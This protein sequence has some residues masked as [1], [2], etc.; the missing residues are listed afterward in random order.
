MRGTPGPALVQQVE[1]AVFGPEVVAP[2]RHAVRLVDGEQRAARA[3][4]QVEEARRQQALGR[5]V[6]Q[7]EL[8][9]SSA[10]DR[11][12]LARVSVELRNAA[13]T[14]SCAAPRPGPA[15]AR[16]AARRRSP[17]PFAQQRRHLVAQRL[18]AAGGHQHQRVAAAAAST[19]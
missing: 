19:R 14:P 5:D 11:A 6:Q 4:E 3:L 2:L 9:A 12:R 15:S 17:V 8:A 13:R 7:V 16:S 1:L 18:A 10:L